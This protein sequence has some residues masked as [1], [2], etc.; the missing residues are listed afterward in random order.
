MA[1]FTSMTE[2]FISI[3]NSSIP[4]VVGIQSYINASV[5]FPRFQVVSVRLWSDA[6]AR[7]LTIRIRQTTMP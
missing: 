5:F 1:V 7:S 4:D 2:F 3:A 6:M